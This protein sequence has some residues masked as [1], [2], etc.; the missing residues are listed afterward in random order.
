MAQHPR[1]RH[2]AD[3]A[4]PWWP[5]LHDA[6]VVILDVI[7][8]NVTVD[9]YVI[10]LFVTS[11]IIT[12]TITSTAS[13]RL[14]HH[15]TAS[16]WHHNLSHLP[17]DVVLILDVITLVRYYNANYPLN[18]T[19]WS[20]NNILVSLDSSWPLLSKSA[21]T[22]ATILEHFF[23]FEL[24]DSLFLKKLIKM[25]KKNRN[26]FFKQFGLLKLFQPLVLQ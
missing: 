3:E 21:G 11:N 4:V 8:L 10:T 26:I 9:K 12:S 19:K 1:W 6:V 24:P 14:I 18:L 2:D 23:L 13:G 20:W 16:V 15:G 22:P 25:Q 17:D 7:K 5:N